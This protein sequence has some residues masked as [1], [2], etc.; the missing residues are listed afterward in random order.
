MLSQKERQREKNKKTKDAWHF[1][2]AANPALIFCYTPC[3]L[4]RG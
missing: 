3:K 2:Y 1:L 4:D